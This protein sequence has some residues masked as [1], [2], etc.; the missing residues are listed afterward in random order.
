M[1][2]FKLWKELEQDQWFE[3]IVE[4]NIESTHQ[5]DEVIEQ[6]YRKIEQLKKKYSKK[7]KQDN[8]EKIAKPWWTP[9]LE[10][11]R[12]KVRAHRRRYQ[13]TRDETQRQI[14]KKQYYEA[15]TTYQ[16]NINESKDLSWKEYCAEI[17]KKNPF[18]LAYKIASNKVK[19]AIILSPIRK[20]DGELTTGH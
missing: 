9:Q 1:G 11:E 6:M 4:H 15:F 8:L 14:F 3:E 2:E 13:K 20:A 19:K 5:L 17:R 16:K 7:V 10:I 18:N 12:K